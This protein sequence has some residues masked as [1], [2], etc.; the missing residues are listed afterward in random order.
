[1]ATVAITEN[2]FKTEVEESN[3]PVLV[4]FWA[5]W[6]GPCQMLAPELEKLSD[7]YSSVK[8]GKVDINN[9]VLLAQKYGVM[10]I[11]T[12]ILFESGK[13]SKVLE[14]YRTKDELAD[15]LGLE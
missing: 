15:E 12:L 14:G 8:V 9:E 13:P 4:D 2:N 1:M 3:I 7:Q 11:P 6:C 5:S 10:R